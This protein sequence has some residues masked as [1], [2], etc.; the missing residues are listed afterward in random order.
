MNLY[1][2]NHE[3]YIEKANAS[4]PFTKIIS[5]IFWRN[6]QLVPLNS[7]LNTARVVARDL[8]SIDFVLLTANCLTNLQ[9]II[10][11]YFPDVNFDE[12]VIRSENDR[13]KVYIPNLKLYEVKEEEDE[14]WNYY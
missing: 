10:L 1:K 4:L 6:R 7:C 14:I 5:G 11:H 13:V 8:T 12:V 2:F 9:T 3:I